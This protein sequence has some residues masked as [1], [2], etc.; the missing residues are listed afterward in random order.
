MH[1]DALDGAGSGATRNDDGESLARAPQSARE[2]LLVATITARFAACP[3]ARGAVSSAHVQSA[4]RAVGAA[5]GAAVVHYLARSLYLP[6][7][8]STRAIQRH[9]HLA[10]PQSTQLFENGPTSADGL[11]RAFLY[12]DDD[13]TIT[14]FQFVV[15]SARAQ[16]LV[17]TITARFQACPTARGSV[18]VE[19]VQHAICD[20]GTHGGLVVLHL[21]N[22]RGLPVP[23]ATAAPTT[24]TVHSTLAAHISTSAFEA[25]ASS[26]RGDG[27][28]IL[29]SNDEFAIAAEPRSRSYGDGSLPISA[30]PAGRFS[31]TT[32]FMIAAEPLS[33][34][35]GGGSPAL[36]AQS[37]GG[38][39]TIT[40]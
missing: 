27:A 3:I 40:P 9:A 20:V 36:G 33:R 19:D 34:S 13:D 23:P 25:G 17:T 21:A 11:F 5:S 2:Q 39:S 18:S 16:R 38:R 10:A 26:T 6:D 1:D 24:A 29:E 28:P 31:N 7:P 15:Q 35:G 32:P 37:T 14:F 8:P 12:D 22:G 4:I 30:Q